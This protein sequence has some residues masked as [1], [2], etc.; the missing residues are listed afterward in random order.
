MLRH[1][2]GQPCSHNHVTVAHRIKK[3][4]KKHK[5]APCWVIQN[6]LSKSRQSLTNYLFRTKVENRYFW[7]HAWMQS[8]MNNV[9]Q[10]VQDINDAIEQIFCAYN[11]RTLSVVSVCMTWWRLLQA[12]SDVQDAAVR[13]TSVLFSHRT[14]S[15]LH[16]WPTPRQLGLGDHL[17]TADRARPFH[18]PRRLSATSTR[19][20][21]KRKW[22]HVVARSAVV[23]VVV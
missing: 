17:A 19:L 1:Q 21:R 16:H 22:R 4:Q 11:N 3:E 12:K 18:R 10:P 14:T 5:N 13:F 15:Q 6:T 9:R 2:A 7:W 20:R 8:G 23:C